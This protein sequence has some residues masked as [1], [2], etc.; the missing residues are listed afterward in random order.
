MRRVWLCAIVLA[1][2][3]GTARADDAPAKPAKAETYEA[4][5]A[6]FDAAKKAYD[7]ASEKRGE[8]YNAA[9]KAAGDDKEKKDEAR[10]QYMEANHKNPSPLPAFAPRFLAVA[11]ANPDAKDTPD[12]L[13]LAFRHGGGPKDKSGV[14]NQVFEFLRDQ[15]YLARVELR[16]FLRRLAN[17]GD[18]AAVQF[19]RDA[20]TKNPD[21]KTQALAAQALANHYEMIAESGE[22]LEKNEKHGPPARSG[23]ARRRSTSR[24]PRQRRPRPSA[25]S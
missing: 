2:A 19:V 16:P 22:R 12:A 8:E 9:L 10:K 1:C 5:R 7:E 20:I 25:T 15:G 14:Y 24:S 3:A 21:R 13:L 6:E 17:F 11:R 23:W 18:E 4:L